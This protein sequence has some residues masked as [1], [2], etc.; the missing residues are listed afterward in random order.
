MKWDNATGY[1]RFKGYVETLIQSLRKEDELDKKDLVEY[2]RNIQRKMRTIDTNWG[3][4]NL[5]KTAEEGLESLL[6]YYDYNPEDERYN[7]K[8]QFR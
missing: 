1:K 3:K 6:T 5:K 2:H 7:K 4:Q 8:K